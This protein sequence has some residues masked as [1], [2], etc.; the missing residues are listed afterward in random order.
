[1]QGKLLEAVRAGDHPAVHAALKAGV[2]LQETDEHGW[3]ALNWAA[4]KGDLTS[5]RALLDAGA[6]AARTG[7]DERTPYQIALAAGHRE[8]AGLLR[9][10]QKRSGAAVESAQPYCKAYRLSELRQFPHWHEARLNGK[11][12]TPAGETLAQS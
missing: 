9:E 12:T 8:A 3:S 11:T 2:D 10:A 4:G 6:D 7:K 1:S 5:I